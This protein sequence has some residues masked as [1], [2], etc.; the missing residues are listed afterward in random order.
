MATGHVLGSLH[1]IF[2]SDSMTAL[3]IGL[4]VIAGCVAAVSYACVAP[5]AEFFRPVLVHGSAESGNLV[6]TFDDGPTSPF[7]EQILDILAERRVPATFFLCGKNV[8]RHPEIARRI[9][10]EGHTIG[11]HTYSHP[12]LL[13]RTRKFIAG[14]IERTQEIIER[15]TGVRPSL[16]RPPYGARWFGL[17]P[18]LNVRG[19]NLVMWSAAGFDW[20]YK[21]QA[22][23]KTT[24]R[25]M[26]SGSV[27]LLHDGHERQPP[28]KVDQSCTVDALPA[29]IDAAADAGLEF[30]PIGKFTS[31][32]A[33]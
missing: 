18:T 3:T 23:I 6:L 13:L 24:T 7:T 25:K 19:L 12:L 9:L 8:E 4:L 20:K 29:I 30:V 14:E 17:M 33:Q 21:T 27:I 31:A 16:F 11:N 22:I 2:F 26:R 5:M 1:R 10:R 32:V 28:E 15:V